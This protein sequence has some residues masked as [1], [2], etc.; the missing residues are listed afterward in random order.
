[1]TGRRNDALAP[2]EPYDATRSDGTRAVAIDSQHLQTRQA[3][4]RQYNV[5]DADL[6]NVIVGDAKLDEA[7]FTSDV[8][9]QRS[10]ASFTKV[11]IV[12]A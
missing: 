3:N 12:K 4:S 11:A 7:R 8:F 9:R 10:G 2:R 1:M 6:V 5:L